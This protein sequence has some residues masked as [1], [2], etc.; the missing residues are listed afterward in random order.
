MAFTLDQL[1]AFVE[2]VEQGSFRGAAIN[3]GKHS[4]TISE[5]VANLEIDLGFQLFERSKRSI[6]LTGRGKDMY[7]F[8]KPVLVEA[9]QFQNK[10][11]SVLAEHPSHF[12]V[13]IDDTLRCPEVV[14]CYQAVLERFPSINLKVLNGDV[15]QIRSWL[16]SGV[17]DVGMVATSMNTSADF[18][19]SRSFAFELINIISAK[20]K[21]MNRSLDIT[22]VRATPQ[23]L[24]NFMLEAGLEGTH[25]ISNR[26]L[27]ANN[28]N[29]IV[30]MVAAGLGWS[31][32]PS[33]LAQR[34]IESGQ[35]QEFNIDDARTELWFSEIIHLSS[36]T[37][38]PA[39]QCFIDAAK[40]VT[41]KL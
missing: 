29:E 30:E 22:T 28:A 17:A 5:L 31:M 12:T 33:Y 14:A 32:M 36:K 20:I 19:L 13:A 39:M 34:Y 24:H 15:M 8:A 37:I 38:N 35:V 40:Q 9:G 10:A 27:V 18:T 1:S 26:V 41:D 21:I 7:D 6:I 23:I 16:R 4:S 25:K 3:I 11:D 2:T